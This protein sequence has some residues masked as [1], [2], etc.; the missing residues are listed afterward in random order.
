MDSELIMMH[1]PA[2]TLLLVACV[3]C[4][5]TCNCPPITPQSTVMSG[6]SLKLSL[7]PDSLYFI[8]RRISPTKDHSSCFK[9]CKK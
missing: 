4:A 2:S 3:T 8:P 1:T 5:L 6:L 7:A 9:H